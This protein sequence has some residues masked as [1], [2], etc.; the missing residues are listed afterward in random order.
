[1]KSLL[2]VKIKKNIFEMP[3]IRTLYGPSDS[4]NQKMNSGT[5]EGSMLKGIYTGGFSRAGHGY[6]PLLSQM[7]KPP[8]KIDTY[9]LPVLLAGLVIFFAMR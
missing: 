5:Q 8:G 7:P 6:Y 4:D 2:N 3:L 9:A 1:L